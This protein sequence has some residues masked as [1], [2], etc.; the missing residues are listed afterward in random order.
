[1]RARGSVVNTVAASS[2]DTPCF[3]TLVRAFAGSHK[4][5]TPAA[6]DIRRATGATLTRVAP[7][8]PGTGEG[9]RVRSRPQA[10][11]PA[12]LGRPAGHRGDPHGCRTGPNWS[13]YGQSG[14]E[15]RDV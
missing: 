14:R 7:R 11:P 13:R 4:N 1:M 6:Y 5:C 12:A 10:R 15:T 3:R 2:N 9:G 8:R